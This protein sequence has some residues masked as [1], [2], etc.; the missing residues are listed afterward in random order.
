M[1][2]N[3]RSLYLAA[4]LGFPY[5]NRGVLTAFLPNNNQGQRLYIRKCR[6]WFT[7]M[8]TINQQILKAL[9]N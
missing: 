7:V 1:L 3:S 2:G 9:A 8:P 4:K 5:P 6:Q